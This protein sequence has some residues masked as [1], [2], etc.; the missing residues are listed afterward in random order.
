MPKPGQVVAT[1]QR[2][3]ATALTLYDELVL[4]VDQKRKQRSLET[5]LAE[6]CVL[7]LAVLWEAFIHDL[8]VSHI[9]DSSE[10]CI[11]FHKD[12][13]K[14]SIEQKNK[15]FSKWVTIEIPSAL[16]RGQIELLVDPNGWNITADS[17]ETLA[18]TANQFLAAQHAIKFSL[19]D[20]DRCFVDFLIA[21]RN[22]LSHRS[23]GALS[24]MKER[25]REVSA[26]DPG[27]PLNGIVTT[28]GAYL[29]AKPVGSVHNRAKLLGHRLSALATKLA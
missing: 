5:M 25:L 8:I 27:S 7:N 21:T 29:K 6:Q 22:Y 17:A 13:V 9:E 16:S 1:F 18:K 10:A 11:R 26:V 23:S 24:I 19:T 28:V 12:R 14:Q 3:I 2:R 15:F 4:A 20:V